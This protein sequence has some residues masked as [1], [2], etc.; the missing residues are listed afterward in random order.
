MNGSDEHR[1]D[2]VIVGGGAA[3]FQAA[4]TLRREWPEK[5]VLVI[6]AEREIGYYRTLLP[7]FMVDTIAES[8]LFFR[9][10]DEDPGIRTRTGVKVQAIDRGKRR[11]VFDTGETLGYRRLILACGGCPIVPRVC[12]GNACE[13]V[14]AVRYLTDARAAK[15]WIPDHRNIVVLGGGLVGVKTAAHL[16]HDGLSVTVI[17]R[18]R[19]LLPMALSPEAADFVRIH[20]EKLGIR[21]VLG[22]SVEDVQAREGRLVAVQ[23]GGKWI[24]CETLL[25]AAGSI[26]NIGFLCESGL[27]EDGKLPVSPTLQTVDENIFALGDAVTI[28]G[29]TEA[30][31]W[32]WPQAVSQGRLAA[33]N[34]FDPSP[35]PVKSSSR[36]NAMNLFGLSLVVLGAPVAD[37]VRVSFSEPHAGIYRELFVRNDR[38][39]GGALVG[40]ITGAG[41]LH[42]AMNAGT[43]V[44]TDDPALLKPDG[45]AFSD[46][47]WNDVSRRSK[48]FFLP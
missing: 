31:P 35:V 44:D 27:V 39:A 19:T 4:R 17:E 43:P 47:A 32:T 36:V 20:L 16:A 38:I 6:D 9:H 46:R 3:G 29:E 10:P 48:A 41:P 26:P 12:P 23:A 25:I 11:L 1:V 7:Q 15:K 42:A 13:G 33:R 37:A 8:K 45:R 28:R 30:T 34:L 21:L 2:C 14:F 18:E 40:D 22:C 24:L 5:S